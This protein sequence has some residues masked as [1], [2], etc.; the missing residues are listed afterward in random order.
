MDQYA[1]PPF[2]KISYHL[3]PTPPSVLFLFN[4]QSLASPLTSHALRLTIPPLS[5][6]G[7]D[8]STP[9]PY[10]PL[11][12]LPPAEADR[13]PGGFVVHSQHSRHESTAH[14]S[15]D[16]RQPSGSVLDV[17]QQRE[18]LPSL[19]GQRSQRGGADLRRRLPGLWEGGREGRGREGKGRE[20]KG[21][22]GKGREGKGR[23][24]KGE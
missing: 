19:P 14:D 16:S 15:R 3:V 18:L 21:R 1:T 11:P 10:P 8:G 4:V 6:V 7:V 13:L 20:G 5:P 22:E 23:E 9:R 17:R 2:F 12:P 24:G